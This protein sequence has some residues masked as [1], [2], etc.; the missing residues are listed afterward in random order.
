MD[1]ALPDLDTELHR[2]YGFDSFRPGQREAVEGTMAGRDVLAIMPTGSGKSRCLTRAANQIACG[3]VRGKPSSRKPLAQS[4]R[5]VR[6]ATT[7][8]TAIPCRRN[9]CPKARACS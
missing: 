7:A 6:L 8:S 2:L 5:A 3:T 4:G 1:V 9:V